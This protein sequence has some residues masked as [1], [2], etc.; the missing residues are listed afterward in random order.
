[1]AAPDLAY[2]AFLATGFILDHFVLWRGFLKR[3]PADPAGARRW[4]WSGW[5][6]LLWALTIV[7]AAVWAWQGRTLAALGMVLPGGWRLLVALG[8]VSVL[9]LYF[10]RMAAGMARTR[11]TKR[12]R[13]PEPIAR[14]LPHDGA[15]LGWFVALS[16]SAGF[17][18]E[19]IFRG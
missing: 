8:V 1:M 4:I 12:V 9:V 19:F 6:A 2:V 13:M 10:A 3:S 11:R 16:L 17:C 14:L 5:L 18:E 7:G 15:E